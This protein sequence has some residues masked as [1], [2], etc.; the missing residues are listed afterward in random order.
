MLIDM[1]TVKNTARSKKQY[2]FLGCILL[3]A[4][5]FYTINATRS[6]LWYD[7]AIEYFYSKYITGPVPGGHN[8]ANMLER[9]LH[10]F[11]PPLYNILMYFWLGLF[12]SEFGFRFAGILTTLAGS[13][14]KY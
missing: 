9:I 1:Q 4:L 11:Q 10:T 13:A 12:D 14:G 8:S 3:I 7:E 6:G 2:I 5:V